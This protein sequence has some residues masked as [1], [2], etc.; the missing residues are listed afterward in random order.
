MKEL[1]LR[2]R[3]RKLEHEPMEDAMGPVRRLWERSKTVMEHLAIG[4]DIFARSCRDVRFEDVATRSR[5]NVPESRLKEM[6]RYCSVP[7]C[8]IPGGRLPE[9]LLLERSSQERAAP[10]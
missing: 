2:L 4:S 9:R 8:P 3:W 1:K 10:Q 7:H 6:L 5:G